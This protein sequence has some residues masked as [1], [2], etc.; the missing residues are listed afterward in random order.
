MS[1]ALRF[2]VKAGQTYHVTLVGVVLLSSVIGHVP[3][4]MLDL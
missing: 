2:A 1:A 3:V 4:G